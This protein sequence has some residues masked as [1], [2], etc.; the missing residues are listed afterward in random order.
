MNAPGRKDRDLLDA[1][2]VAQ[3]LRHSRDWFYRQYPGLLQRGFPEPVPGMGRR[4]DPAAINAWLDQQANPGPP[5]KAPDELDQLL[6][7][8]A[9][10][11]AGKV[12]EEI[13]PC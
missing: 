10:R 12:E 4:W 7:R 6:E 13:R 2:G 9:A 8:R 1:A 11:L 5:R 3:K